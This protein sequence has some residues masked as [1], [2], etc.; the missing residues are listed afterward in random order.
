MRFFIIYII[1]I[2][3]TA[4]SSKQQAQSGTTI[5][6]NEYTLS[7]SFISKGQGINRSKHQDFTNFIQKFNSQNNVN[8]T[9]ESYSWGREGERDYCFKLENLDSKIVQNFISESK[10]LLKNSELVLYN[11]NGQCRHKR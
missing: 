5:K 9:P 2:I 8:I 10:E 4:C 3:S 6:D 1:L 7:V 11:E